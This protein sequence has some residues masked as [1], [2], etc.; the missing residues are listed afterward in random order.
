M[1]AA[2][3]LVELKFIIVEDGGQF[4]MTVLDKMRR[5]L[6]VDNSEFSMVTGRLHVFKIRK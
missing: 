6:C 5:G 2:I 3:I 1:V 4:V